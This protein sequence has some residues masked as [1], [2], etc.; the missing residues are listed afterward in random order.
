MQFLA[1]VSSIHEPASY[2]STSKDSKWVE[3]MHQKLSALQ[4][5][6]TWDL[7]GLQPG[8]QVIGSKWVYK[9]KLH[10]NGTLDRYKA[11]LVAKGYH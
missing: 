10:P 2:K 5:N 4:K 3:A 8:K 1:N 6:H 9:I 7:T 11:K